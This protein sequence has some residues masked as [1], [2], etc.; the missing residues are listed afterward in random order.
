MREPLTVRIAEQTRVSR[1]SGESCWLTEGRA[2]RVFASLS[3]DALALKH[4]FGSPTAC[5]LATIAEGARARPVG[6]GAVEEATPTSTAPDVRLGHLVRPESRT[7]ASVLASR[8]SANDLGSLRLDELATVL[9]RSGR[10]RAWLDFPGGVQ[11]TYRP[12]PSAGARHPC[13]LLVAASGVEGLEDGWWS[14]NAA[15]CAV[16]AADSAIGVKDFLERQQL[17]AGLRRPPAGAIVVIANFRRTLLRYPAGTVHVW[18]DAGALLA[19]LHLS[20]SDIGLRSVITGG[21]D[22][23]AAG[24]LSEV[25]TDVGALLLG[26]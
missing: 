21:V 19:T 11:L 22:V 7:L 25:T 17:L 5:T 24:S 13:S 2:A 12:V 20:A 23:L 16:H 3:V 9:V 8:Y 6:L 10:I 18:R 4:E 15:T 26:R 14:F 1:D